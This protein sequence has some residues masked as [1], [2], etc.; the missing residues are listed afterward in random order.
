MSASDIIAVVVE[1]SLFALVL[2][3]GLESRWSE[4]IHVLRHP[5]F[6]F[7]AI[8]AVNVIVPAVAVLL[9]L[10]LPIAPW[11]KA[12]LVMM[13]ISP[14][15]P[16]AP[17]KML[18]T[19]AERTSV[20]G[21]YVAL[22]LAAVVI[23]PL[24]AL[25]LKPLAPHGVLIPASFVARFVAR[26]VLLPLLIGVTVHS[27]WER[28]GE[29]SARLLRIAALAILLP[30]AVL[31]VARFASIF[32]SLVGDG[33]LAVI[34]ATIGSAIAA[35]Y[36]LGG[37]DLAVR[38]ALGDAAGSRHPGLAAAIA[39]LHSNDPRILASILLFFVASILF[40]VVFAKLLSLWG[41][42]PVEVRPAHR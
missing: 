4:L 25:I 1:V 35:G 38:K 18:K 28:F 12:G 10:V 11:T 9:C 21:T 33:T 20:I 6:L 23:V 22:I 7:R 40:S 17:L 37:P 32:P 16:F 14:L 13:S 3:I 39:Q 31:I 19:G 41:A 36:A 30:I 8:L 29:R 5:A 2:S 15:A 24:T 27:F 42:P 34:A 26:T